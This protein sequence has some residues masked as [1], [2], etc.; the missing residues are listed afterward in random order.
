MV[1]SKG[2]T[3]RILH[4]TEAMGGGVSSALFDYVRHTPELEHH[5]LFVSRPETKALGEQWRELFESVVELPAG[6]FQRI[7]E[8]RSQLKRLRPDVVH[9]HSSFAGFYA[10]LA[11]LKS[12]KLEQ[13]HTPHCYAFERLD[14][15][16]AIRFALRGIEA[17]LSRNTT[18]IAGCS[19]REVALAERWPLSCR[20]SYLPNLA[21]KVELSG[22]EEDSVSVRTEVLRVVGAGRLGAQKDPEFFISALRGLR[23][24]GYHVE[25]TWVGGGDET[26]AHHLEEAGVK[27]TGW[28]PRAEVFRTF[29][30]QDIY[31]HTAAWEGFPL[32]VLEASALHLATVVRDIPAFEGIDL[33]LKVK[34][35]AELVSL[36]DALRDPF[37]RA[38]AVKKAQFALRSN[39]VQAQRE[40]LLK[41]YSVELSAHHAVSH[42][43]VGT[44]R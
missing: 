9:S 42:S 3:R 13:V 43:S 15:S 7:R 21:P 6:H 19:P 31:L 25:A 14:L 29:N 36:W 27:V 32:A 28:L 16:A 23:K 5:L 44:T 30:C 41:V 4:V 18:L 12:R 24:A 22:S 20:A 39:T 35:S 37:Y 17:V 33:P 2:K 34:T 26:L 40:A 1:L 11:A 10:R 38:D 8:V